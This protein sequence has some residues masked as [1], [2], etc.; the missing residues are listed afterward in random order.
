MEGRDGDVTIAHISDIHCG[1]PDFVPNLM[2][3]AINEINELGPDIV[4][5]SGATP[6][7]AA[8]SI[9]SARNARTSA[10]TSS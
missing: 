10:T 3:R 1:G 9:R 4:I 5:C 2:E 6:R 8:S 7:A